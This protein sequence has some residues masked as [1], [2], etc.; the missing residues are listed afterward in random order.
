MLLLCKSHYKTNL[1]PSQVPLLKSN[2]QKSLKQPQLSAN[3]A[4]IFTPI[5]LRKVRHHVPNCP[6]ILVGTKVDLRED[7]ETLEKL[8]KT[9]HA[10]TTHPK[11]L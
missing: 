5:F 7:K 3:S 6:I 1:S 11:V 2:A 4:N 8:K 9:G 10:P